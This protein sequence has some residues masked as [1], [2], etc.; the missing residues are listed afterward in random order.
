LKHSEWLEIGAKISDLWPN[1]T[2][3][4][5]TMAS[6]YDLFATVDQVPAMKAI[7][8]LCAEGREFAPAPGV[9]LSKALQIVIAS[10]PQLQDP[11]LTRELTAEEQD[12]ATRMAAA[13]AGDRARLVQATWLVFAQHA[14]A[15]MSSADGKRCDEVAD[16]VRRSS[17]RTVQIDPWLDD[18]CSVGRSL[19]SAW[20]EAVY[21]MR[22][23]AFGNLQQE[24]PA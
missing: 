12:R 9:V 8:E 6:A 22:V 7:A 24:M 23:A 2:W 16:R 17:M 20:R 10:T 11:D 14:K 19:W 3:P 1:Q 18:C 4:P 15:C 13:L 5:E 21:D